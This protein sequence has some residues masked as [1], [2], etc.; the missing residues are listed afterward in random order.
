MGFCNQCSQVYSCYVPIRDSFRAP[1]C[2]TSAV[3]GDTARIFWELLGTFVSHCANPLNPQAGRTPLFLEW[4]AG[5]WKRGSVNVDRFVNLFSLFVQIRNSWACT[6][7][8]RCCSLFRADHMLESISFESRYAM[9]FYLGSMLMSSLSQYSLCFHVILTSTN[10]ICCTA[11]NRE[12][13]GTSLVNIP[14]TDSLQSHPIGH[15]LELFGLWKVGS[16]EISRDEAQNL[17]HVPR[18][19]MCGKG[20]SEDE[21][22]YACSEETQSYSPVKATWNYKGFLAAQL[23]NDCCMTQ[24]CTERPGP[25]RRL[26]DMPDFHVCFDREFCV[27]ILRSLALRDFPCSISALRKGTAMDNSQ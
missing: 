16:L 20:T 4:E 14:Q 8:C 2:E 7:G 12:C 1:Q 9:Y 18:W 15:Q 22:P 6:G 5:S 23:Q 19:K 24:T 27:R 17:V 11:A 3:Q 13:E 10:R 21:K 25:F 26:F